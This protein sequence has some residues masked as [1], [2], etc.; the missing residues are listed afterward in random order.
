MRFGDQVIEES[1]Q[2]RAANRHQF[3]GAQRVETNFQWRAVHRHRRRLATGD[4]VVG[5]AMADRWQA[6]MLGPVQDEQ[7]T[8][9]N[10]VA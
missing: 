8:A 4:G 2:R 3:D 10:H 1:F 7:Q 6:D 5:W 9:A